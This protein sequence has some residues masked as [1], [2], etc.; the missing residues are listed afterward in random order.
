MATSANCV[1]LCGRVGSIHD[2]KEYS[3]GTARMTFSL[4]T[5]HVYKQKKS[6]EWHDIVTW[7]IVAKMCK[8]NLE[9]GMFVTIMGPLRS[10]VFIGKKGRT[11]AVTVEADQIVFMNKALMTMV[12]SMGD[13]PDDDEFSGYD[14]DDEARPL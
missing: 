8:D 1:M 4:G 10:Q 12:K 6:T 5:D 13:P 7:G 3:G 9:V 11:R 2:Y 14:D